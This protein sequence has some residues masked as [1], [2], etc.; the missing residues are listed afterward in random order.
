MKI[1]KDQRIMQMQSE[2]FKI[3]MQKESMN[4][5]MQQAEMANQLKFKQEQAIRDNLEAYS[6]AQNNLQQLDINSEV[7][8]YKTSFST[9]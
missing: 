6:K 7:T 8:M 5:Q 3:K 9:F 1:E 4:Q 2:E